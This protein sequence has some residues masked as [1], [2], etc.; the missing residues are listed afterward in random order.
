MALERR[1]D[2][3]QQGFDTLFGRFDQELTAVLTD[4]LPQEIKAFFN[5]YHLCFL[6]RQ[7]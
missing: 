2:F 1:A 5:V 3:E 4:I 7:G 6:D